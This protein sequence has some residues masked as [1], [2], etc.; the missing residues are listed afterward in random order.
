MSDSSILSLVSYGQH[1]QVNDL[2]NVNRFLEEM[3]TLIK[4]Q[5]HINSSGAFIAEVNDL[6][7]GLYNS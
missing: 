3:R 2:G 4:T 7:H 5:R 1:I 6:V